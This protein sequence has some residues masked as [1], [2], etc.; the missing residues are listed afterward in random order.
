MADERTTP[1][2]RTPRSDG[3]RTRQAILDEAARLA[4]VEGLEGLSL[5]RLAERVGM[6]KSGLFAHFGSKEELQLA[7]VER[8]TAI[9]TE[10]VFEP[11]AEAPNGLERLQALLESFLSY[12]EVAVF[13]GGCF[14]ASAVA[15]LDTRSGPVRDRA[16]GVVADW[17]SALEGA[18]RD[19]QAE[20]LIDPGVEPAQLVFELDAYALLGNGQFVASGSKEALD[21]ARRAIA[22]RLDAVRVARSL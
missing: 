16:L 7:T 11:A 1:R 13:P 3:I 15:E 2:R 20:G 4:T 17:M 21:R 22:N 5:A 9:F 18:V 10:D 6:S 14:F 19:A 12:V 8:A